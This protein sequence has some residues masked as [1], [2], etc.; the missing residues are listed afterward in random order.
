MLEDRRHFFQNLCREIVKSVSDGL[1]AGVEE[2]RQRKDFDEFFESYESS[3]AL[4]LNYPDE[5]LIETAR[6][7]GIEVEG[8]E[9]IEIV[10]EL[11][12]RKGGWF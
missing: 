9:K 8:R 1:K 7:E 3:Y 4:T 6:R 11:F 5:I 10:Q 12:R 2:D